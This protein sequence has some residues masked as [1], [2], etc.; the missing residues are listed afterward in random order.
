MADDA[1]KWIPGQGVWSDGTWVKP[2]SP[3]IFGAA[4]GAPVAPM[5][6]NTN[7]TADDGSD[8][9]KSSSS[10]GWKPNSDST[11]WTMPPPTT[12]WAKGGRTTLELH[13]WNWNAWRIGASTAMVAS[14][15]TN[16]A[17]WIEINGHR[18]AMSGRRRDDGRD[19]WTAGSF[20]GNKPLTGRIKLRGK[21]YTFTIP[22]GGGVVMS[23]NL[24]VGGGSGKPTK[25]PTKK[26]GSSGTKPEDKYGTEGGD[27]AGQESTTIGPDGTWGGGATTA[28]SGDP[29][30]NTP[31]DTPYGG[32][33]DDSGWADNI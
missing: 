1:K 32:S 20:K 15:S 16:G 28:G 22:R 17:E 12:D 18:M 19:V 3:R 26:P 13:H 33:D 8:S 27:K 11:K 6:Y 29:S 21:I 5:W 9:P 25:K 23:I 7:N 24:W 31:P 2:D 30:G 14:S 10:L 4:T